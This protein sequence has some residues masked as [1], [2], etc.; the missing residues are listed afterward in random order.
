VAP[1]DYEITSSFPFNSNEE[2]EEGWPSSFYND[3]VDSNGEGEEERWEDPFSWI[4]YNDNLWNIPTSSSTNNEKETQP[5]R[6]YQARTQQCFG[7]HIGS[8]RWYVWT[9]VSSSSSTAS[10]SSSNG[11]N[12]KQIQLPNDNNYGYSQY[13]SPQETYNH[14][15][16]ITPVG[17]YYTVNSW[18][19]SLRVKSD[20]ILG[21]EFATND[22]G[23]GGRNGAVLLPNGEDRFTFDYLDATISLSQY[24]SKSNE[25]TDTISNP[26]QEV[27][28]NTS[29]NY[30]H[31][32]NYGM[33]Y[34]PQIIKEVIQS[35]LNDKVF[36]GGRSGDGAGNGQELLTQ[37]MNVNYMWSNM[38]VLDFSSRRK[39]KR[40]L[41]RGLTFGEERQP[42]GWDDTGVLRMSSMAIDSSSATKDR[43]LR[44]SG[45]R[46][47]NTDLQRD[48]RS[49]VSLPK[50][51][52][53]FSLQIIAKYTEK[54]PSNQ[55]STDEPRPSE[56][57]RMEN[58]AIKTTQDF[59]R[60]T[61]RL[62]NVWR[63][64]LVKRMRMRS[65]YGQECNA[66]GSEEEES[67]P[68]EEEEE[69]S[70][71]QG[72]TPIAIS[73][74]EFNPNAGIN[75]GVQQTG[76]D[77]YTEVSIG[78][79]NRF[80]CDKLLPLYYYE[81]DVL[82]V[83]EMDDDND[84]GGDNNDMERLDR[85]IELLAINDGIDGPPSAYLQG[86][87]NDT[88]SSSSGMPVWLLSTIIVIVILAMFAFA[89]GLYVRKER[90][91][92][93][94]EKERRRRVK[95]ERLAAKEERRM[96]KAK[97]KE[98]KERR[99]QQSREV[100]D[101]LIGKDIEGVNDD[102]DVVDDL[103]EGRL[104]RSLPTPNAKNMSSFVSKDESEDSELDRLFASANS[105]ANKSAQSVE[106]PKPI[107]AQEATAALLSV[108][109][110][111]NKP[112]RRRKKTV[113]SNPDTAPLEM[114]NASGLNYSS[115]TDDKSKDVSTRSGKEVSTVAQE[116]ANLEDTSDGK[117]KGEQEQR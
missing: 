47:S 105:G 82:A 30:I 28:N 33:L 11:A 72:Y 79:V 46:G 100:V 68:L 115:R 81:L 62:M 53:I 22:G 65:G 95:A 94:L 87:E 29:T 15:L 38:E 110:L 50:P 104:T 24:L 92:L 2:E 113:D 18:P 21:M 64:E 7:Y 116:D 31:T 35:I 59:G 42:S 84:G 3:N 58:Q 1:L 34:T 13:L 49:L 102:D 44:G 63:S 60:Y 32:N 90:K 4:P 54:Q 74:E 101:S 5:N 91:K 114:S 107:T 37:S 89:G 86:E 52:L 51:H 69:E 17:M 27:S 16:S 112:P 66:V 78:V 88:S 25:L 83:R 57:T 9:P 99:K 14:I 75:G 106:S 43:L 61:S 40:R 108:N 23:S 71:L 20:L 48:H 76:G 109:A 93:K 77:E 67:P 12:A 26:I 117:D 55:L 6:G 39:L 36:N 80:D 8:R 10:S 70:F 73:D 96:R 98:K 45:I 103:E 19:L 97:K 56:V 111:H 41:L 85:A